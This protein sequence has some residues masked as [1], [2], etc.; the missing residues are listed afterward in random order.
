MS[1]HPSQRPVIGLVAGRGLYPHLLAERV[2]ATGCEVLLAGL[3]GQFT[4]NPRT[5]HL[6]QRTFPIG[7]LGAVARFFCDRKASEC[8]M[9]GGVL[10]SSAL[11]NIR[12]DRHCLS[13]LPHIFFRGDNAILSAVA[14]KLSNLG[15]AIIDA[16]PFLGD[17]LASEGLLAGPQLDRDTLKSLYI[18]WKAAFELGLRDKGQAATAY[19]GHLD[20]LETRDGTDALIARAQGPGAVLAKIVKRNQDRPAIGPSTALL[21]AAKGMRAIAVE[22]DGVLLL[23]RER[24]M[25]ICQ[26]RGIS[27]LSCPPSGPV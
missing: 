12:P 27:L 22:A 23:E 4:L 14:D 26:R 24:L 20:G 16:K 10:W 9:A 15:V 11:G 2:A 19:R 8:I 7:A 5:T 25:D 3:E 6:L 17:M 18:A 21:A 1:P 13:L